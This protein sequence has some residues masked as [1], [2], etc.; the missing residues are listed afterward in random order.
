[1]SVFH[2]IPAEKRERY[3][4]L[5]V[6][7]ERLEA[8]KLDFEEL[9]E[10][11]ELKKEMYFDSSTL[12]E[13][14]RSLDE[15]KEHKAYQYALSVR[16][17]EIPVGKYVR[18]MTEQ[19]LDDMDKSENDETFGFVFDYRLAGKINTM[20]GLM[21]APSGIVAGTPINE[22]LA[23]FQWFFIM[24]SMCWKHRDDIEKRRYEKNVLLIARKSGKTFMTAVMLLLLLLLEPK[25]SNFY[26]VAPD[27]ELSSLILN[28]MK[29]LID[30][31]PSLSKYM[32]GTQ[33]KIEFTPKQSKFTPLAT[34]NNRM[35]G[36][37][38]TAFVADEIGALR[39]NYPISAMESSQ[40][41]VKNRTGYLISTAYESLDN[42]MT[43]EVET[44]Q[45]VLNGEIDDPVLFALLYKPDDPELWASSD[46]ELLK[47]NPLA[48]DLEDTYNFLKLQR[49][50]AIDNPARRKNFLTKHMNIFV[51]GEEAET[52]L[53]KEDVERVVVDEGTHD[54]YGKDV[55][56]G[57]DLSETN[58]NTAVAM[59][60]Y[61][62]DDSTVMAKAWTF[63]PD[64]KEAEKSK[65]EKID[66]SDAVEQG[67][68]FRS[69]GRVVDYDQIKQFIEQLE[70]EYGVNIISIGYDRW[71]GRATASQLSN[72]GYDMI[73]IEQ[74]MKGL[75]P[76]T[77]LLRESILR[78]HFTFETNYILQ[79]NLLNAKM[80]TNTNMSYMLN[81]KQSDGKIDMAAALVDALAIVQFNIDE[82]AESASSHDLVSFI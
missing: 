70:D 26:S 58:D 1:M 63:Y 44:A 27:L 68:A 7:K 38:A 29:N 74:N 6:K 77:K 30:A 20:T 32:G 51:N 17:N 54:W 56:I 14:Y 16:N 42:P 23:G 64:E 9:D 60:S 76:G 65:I 43:Q 28:E 13:G 71:N 31:S 75:Y 21:K 52:F 11:N 34:S 82:E 61:N 80:V 39:N 18:K 67:W 48:L 72:Q 22:M 36:R 53:T 2:A 45:K 73:E 59:V 62:E 69:S 24:V 55:Y 19:F 10:F 47:A 5:K 4:E 25:Y 79:M 37:L 66:Y 35:D 15:F 81:K 41:N 46:E 3:E 57:L 8:R 12:K 78:E 40:M 49:Q 33:G 50:R